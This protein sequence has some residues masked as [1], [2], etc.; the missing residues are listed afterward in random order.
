[1]HKYFSFSSLMKI[2]RL[3]KDSITNG[4]NQVLKVFEGGN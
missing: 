4:Q 1:M 3:A 2:S